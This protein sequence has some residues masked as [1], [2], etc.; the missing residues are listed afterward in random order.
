MENRSRRKVVAISMPQSMYDATAKRLRKHKYGSMSEYIRDLIRKDEWA[1]FL[2]AHKNDPN[3][4]KRV[5]D[6]TTREWTFR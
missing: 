1:E 6:T 3:E 5:E 2:V 4:R